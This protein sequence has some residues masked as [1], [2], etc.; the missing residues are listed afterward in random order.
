MRYITILLLL[1]ISHFASA[2]SRFEKLEEY[3][4]GL[5]AG[6]LNTNLEDY[7]NNDLIFTSAELIGGYKKNS[8]VSFDIRIG[9]GTTS[10][11]FV[12]ETSGVEEVKI[13][14]YYSLYWRPES[15]NE[16][17]KLYALIGYSTVNTKIE[18]DSGSESGLSYGAGVGFRLNDD[19]NINFEWRWL[20]NTD[21]AEFSLLTASVDYRF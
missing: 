8:Y 7:G 2:Q 5:G 9:A 13:S 4:V 3:F 18:D 11:E 21:I 6:R 12:N 20:L 1:A 10:E 16:D 15:A 19:M 17:A 14:N